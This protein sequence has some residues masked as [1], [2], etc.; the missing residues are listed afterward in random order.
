MHESSVKHEHT[1]IL[2]RA[3]PALGRPLSIAPIMIVAI[4]SQVCHKRRVPFSTATKIHHARCEG[5]RMSLALFHPLL[6]QVEVQLV[7]GTAARPRVRPKLKALDLVL[8]N[9]VVFG[10]LRVSALYHAWPCGV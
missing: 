1:P 3:Q 7:P 6:V 2:R 9:R 10:D 5:M 4:Y 8:E